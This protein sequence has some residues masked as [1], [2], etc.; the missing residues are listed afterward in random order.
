MNKTSKNPSTHLI[1][2]G[3][4]LFIV[5]LTFATNS[6]CS[7]SKNKSLDASQIVC[8]DLL[9]NRLLWSQKNIVDYDMV[10]R[11]LPHS[12]LPAA[13]PVLIKVRNNK[14]VSIEPV[15]PN[16]RGTLVFYSIFETVD[17]MFERI[18]KDLEEEAQVKVL[19]NAEL[20]YAEKVYVTPRLSDAYYELHIDKFDIVK[21]H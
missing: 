12:P 21:S 2:S 9:R 7:I 16:T 17:K 6:A 18:R 13:S 15:S 19:F 3:S 1:I 5:C 14:A 20:G 8:A 10:I 4:L 11:Y